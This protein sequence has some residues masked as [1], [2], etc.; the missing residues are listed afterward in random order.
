MPPRIFV[1][2]DPRHR[3]RP[4]PGLRQVLRDQRLD[5]VEHLRVDADIGYAHP[6]AI[7]SAR[8][9]QMRGLL[10]EEGDGFGR[11]HG[12]PHDSARCAVDAA[13]QIDRQHRR[14]AGVDRIDHL[15]RVALHRAIEPGAE[16]RVDD[17]RRL[18][19]RLRVERQHRI[20]PALRRQRRIAL[21]AVALAKQDH[22]DLAAARGELGGGDKAIAAIVAA[23][24]DH[25]D[26]PLLDQVHRGFSDGLAGAHHQREARRAGCDGQPIGTLHLGGGQNVHAESSIASPFREA[27][28]VTFAGFL[29]AVCIWID[30]FAYLLGL[31][32]IAHL[33][34]YQP[35]AC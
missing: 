5:L 2:V 22:R 20:F 11:L 15:Q 10:A 1:A 29:L 4:A 31:A 13:R 14:T 32:I 23:A 16:Q 21:Q 3:K 25:D 18:A 8:Q 7:H 24:G 19:E 27:I 33:V 34:R 30:L 28:P 9:Q 17:Q 26:R 12:G 35:I 6:T